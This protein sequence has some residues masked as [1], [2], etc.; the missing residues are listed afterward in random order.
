MS[1]SVSVSVYECTRILNKL[2]SSLGQLV[3]TSRR[4]FRGP[5]LPECDSARERR[6]GVDHARVHPEVLLLH[7]PQLQTPLVSLSVQHL[8]PFVSAVRL[9]PQ[10]QH[11]PVLLPQ[12]LYGWATMA[13]VIRDIQTCV[14]RETFRLDLFRKKI[15]TLNSHGRHVRVRTLRLDLFRIFFLKK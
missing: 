5:A 2:T 1:V 12:H 9:L 8:V 15:S 10:T 13:G 14:I 4:V 7:P 6:V 3:T 11:P